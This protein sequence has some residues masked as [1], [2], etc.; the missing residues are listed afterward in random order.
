MKLTWTIALVA[1]AVLC[2]IVGIAWLAAASRSAQSQ[3]IEVAAANH[4]TE[5]V[6][7]KVTGMFCGGCEAAVQHAAREVK[8]VTAVKANADKGT[9]DVTYDPAR[10]TP[11]TIASVITEKSGFKAEAPP[12]S[13]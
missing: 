7:L 2:A 10:A 4:A 6:T 5:A 9:V 12:N 13:L 3:A 1:A 11:E 8:G